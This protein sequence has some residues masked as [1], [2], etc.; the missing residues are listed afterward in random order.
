MNG[1]IDDE[2]EVFDGIACND[3][4]M[5]TQLDEYA[6]FISFP[7]PPMTE[8]SAA[9][10]VEFW[11]KVNDPAV[12]NQDL[13]IFSMASGVNN[14]Q[15]YYHVYIESGSLKCAPF[16]S[17]SSKDPVITFTQFKLTN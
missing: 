9:N 8:W 6:S 16:G 13:L 5:T 15:D 7:T 3:R 14:P 4:H 10:S 11:F 2:R 17:K 12:Y 1:T